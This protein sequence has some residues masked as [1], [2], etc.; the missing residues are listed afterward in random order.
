[1]NSLKALSD[2]ASSFGC[3]QNSSSSFAQG[4]QP[5]LMPHPVLHPLAIRPPHP[6]RPRAQV[7][8]WRCHL[9][10][11]RHLG[12]APERDLIGG[13]AAHSSTPSPRGLCSRSS[14]S[15]RH[16]GL[17]HVTS[18]LIAVWTSERGT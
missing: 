13:E 1:M 9:W 6:P 7:G 4:I 5:L 16:R 17:Q 2:S 18:R 12:L 14:H 10:N 15:T 3:V 11:R 8:R